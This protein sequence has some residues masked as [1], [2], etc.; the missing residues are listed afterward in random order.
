MFLVMV[1]R[2]LVDRNNEHV[3]AHRITN[4]IDSPYIGHWLSLNRRENIN[5]NG[6]N[7]AIVQ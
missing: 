6:S 7:V 1:K 4:N 2:I 5:I 3:L